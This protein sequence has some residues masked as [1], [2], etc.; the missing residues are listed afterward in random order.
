[1]Q[2]TDTLKS[3][4]VYDSVA[5]HELWNRSLQEQE[6]CAFSGVLNGELI[7]SLLQLVDSYLRQGQAIGKRKKNT[8]N[9]LIECLQNIYYHNGSILL[10]DSTLSGCYLAVHR[11][12]QDI[13]IKSCNLILE[14]QIDIIKGHI[15]KLNGMS[16][17]EI[18]NHYL[19]VL[20]KGLLSPVGGAGLG[21]IRMLRESGSPL[22]FGFSKAQNNIWFFNLSIRILQVFPPKGTE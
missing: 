10:E 11:V 20:D 4:L 17:K 5:P 18:H 15:E 6:L 22:A 21:L 19:E 8:I 12:E 16:A 2:D 14:S 1:M 7:S 13:V 3:V 9:V